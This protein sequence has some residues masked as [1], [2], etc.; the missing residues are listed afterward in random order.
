MLHYFK[1]LNDILYVTDYYFY[2]GSIILGSHRI[3]FV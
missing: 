1:I 3:K 2:Y